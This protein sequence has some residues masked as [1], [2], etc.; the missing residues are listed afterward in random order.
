MTSQCFQN[1]VVKA[2][3]EVM[4]T[5]AQAG[6]KISND[7][8]VNAINKLIDEGKIDEA[9]QLYLKDS[10]SFKGNISKEQFLRMWKRHFQG[11][12]W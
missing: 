7:M 10:T 6:V 8:P 12:S 2:Q 5:L 9:Y 4:N 11:E 1:G 3:A